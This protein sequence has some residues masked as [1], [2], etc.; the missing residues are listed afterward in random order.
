[1]QDREARRWAELRASLG[2]ATGGGAPAMPPKEAEVGGER[3]GGQADAVAERTEAAFGGRTLPS[4]PPGL[5]SRM[6]AAVESGAKGDAPEAKEQEAKVS[7]APQPASEVSAPAIEP[8]VGVGQPAD[9]GKEAQ[10][11]G[12]TPEANPAVET[13]PAVEAK[14]VVAEK[15]PEADAPAPA[16]EPRPAMIAPP[17]LPESPA[18]LPVP[19]GP[20]P[21]HQWTAPP[22]PPGVPFVPPLPPAGPPQGGGLRLNP[23]RAEGRTVPAPIRT[24]E[25][26]GLSA[27]SAPPRPA[28]VP[29]PPPP[30]IGFMGKPDAAQAPRPPAFPMIPPVIPAPVAAP[31][32][33]P[34]VMPQPPPQM[35]GP[36]LVAPSMP[37]AIPAAAAT[38]HAAPPAMA[39]A[40]PMA[41]PAPAAPEPKKA[42]DFFKKMAWKKGPE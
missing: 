1:M 42:A 17:K 6:A 22:R 40:P 19:A 12:A 10:P 11:V 13:E 2:R 28:G 29:V 23:I 36:P 34:A 27:P 35:P 25:S 39:P 15:A 33:A 26:L 9:A 14:P 30:P 24:P 32:P 5:A 20:A 4:A 37:P 3:G 18:P 8:A 7:Q 21:G 41:P 38:A 16:V 31:S